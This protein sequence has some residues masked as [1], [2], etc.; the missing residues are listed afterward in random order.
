MGEQLRFARAIRHAE[1][2]SYDGD[3]A[4]LR[5]GVREGRLLGA[6]G[7]PSDQWE[8]LAEDAGFGGARWQDAR[9]QDA[10]T[11]VIFKALYD[12]YG[13]WRLVAVAW[14]AG[15]EIADMVAAKPGLLKTEQ[16]REV[17]EYVGHVMARAGEDIDVTDPSE[18]PTEDLVPKASPFSVTRPIQSNGQTTPTPAAETLKGMLTAMRDRQKRNSVTVDNIEGIEV[19]SPQ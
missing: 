19:G 12:K 16:L 9:A 8:E 5:G 11:R 10:V 4:A 17:D 13:D 6:Y 1:T 15:E 2:G 7:I 14:K 18:P 3:Y